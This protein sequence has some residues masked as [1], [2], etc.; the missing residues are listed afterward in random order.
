MDEGIAQAGL[1]IMG[2]RNGRPARDDFPIVGDILDKRGDFPNFLLVSGSNTRSQQFPL[3]AS[4]L[5]AGH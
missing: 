4:W 2:D 5:P 1:R 3:P